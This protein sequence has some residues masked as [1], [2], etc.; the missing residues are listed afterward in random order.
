MGRAECR[1]KSP[2]CNSSHM[3]VVTGQA[4]WV[5]SLAAVHTEETHRID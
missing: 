5:D 4:D 1:R 2:C 3:L